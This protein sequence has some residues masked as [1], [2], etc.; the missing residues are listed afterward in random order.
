MAVVDGCEQGSVT[1][2]LMARLRASVLAALCAVALVACSPAPEPAA[3]DPGQGG[4]TGDGGGPGAGKGGRGGTTTGRGGAG[5]ALPAGQGGS[6]AGGAVPSA[7][8]GE[9]DG[10]APDAGT[11]DAA[12]PGDAAASSGPAPSPPCAAGATVPAPDGYQTIM[13]GGRARRFLVRVPKSYDGKKPLPLVFALHGGG[14][15]GMSFETRIAAIKNAIGE[16]AM[17]VYPDGL[18]AS[19]GMITWARD[20][21]DDL[22]FMDAVLVW[23]KEKVCFD[24]SRV[25][26]MGQSSGAYFSHT[27][28]CHRPGV[29]RAVATNGGGARANEFVGC[30]GDPVAAWVSNGA[31]DTAHIAAARKARDEWVKINGCT[32]A[33]PMKTTPEP[34]V[35]Y[36]GC[37]TGFPVHYCENSGGHD[38]PSYA[39]MGMASFFLGSFDT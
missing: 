13:S 6:A 28:G 16:R 1:S 11:P 22:A 2:T 32:M 27:L 8:A 24:E 20:F 10:G 33:N 30:K 17:F 4:S 18:A 36:T 34:C 31:A 5:G 19:G 35:S 14:A 39:P 15:N 29:F 37:K 12:A 7:D 23:W 38:I 3:E 26:A 25:F 21:K 9:R